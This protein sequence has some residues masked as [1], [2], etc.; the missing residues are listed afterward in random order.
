MIPKLLSVDLAVHLLQVNFVVQGLHGMTRHLLHAFAE[1]MILIPV[2]QHRLH[3]FVP[4]LHLRQRVPLLLHYDALSLLVHIMLF[5]VAL[6]HI[7]QA[8]TLSLRA[9]AIKG[10]FLLFALAVQ[11]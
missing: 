4:C 10:V 5:F 8:G 11:T 9:L 1:L 3:L 7:L 2:T 6:L